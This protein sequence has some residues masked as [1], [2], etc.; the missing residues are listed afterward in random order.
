MNPLLNK[1]LESDANRIALSA[2]NESV[3]YGELLRRVKQVADTLQQR[4]IRVLALYADNSPNWVVVDLA[5]QMAQIVLLP[6]PLFFSTQQLHHA[7]KSCGNADALL[8]DRL[9]ESALFFQQKNSQ[10][11]A[12]LGYFLLENAQQGVAQLPP[13][14]Q[15]I[16]FTSGSTGTPKGVCLSVEQQLNVAQSLV[17]SIPL[18]RVRH[19]CVLPL[20]TLLENIAG[21]YAPLLR[22][23]EVVIPSLESIGISGSSGLD[24]MKFLQS[25]GEVAPT[26]LI[27]VPE[28]L[29]VL[30]AACEYGWQPPASLKFI[31]VGGARVSASLLHK[32][33]ASG[34][35]VYEGYGLSECASVVSLN[36]P[37]YDVIG[38]SGK[39][40][41]HV[42]V[43]VQNSE[44]V[45]SGNAYLGY[46]NEPDS[47]HQ[48]EIHTGDQGYVDAQG[49][50]HIEGRIKNVLISSFGRN[51][52]PEW[53]ESELLAQ[54]L[55]RQAVVLG[56]A[57]PFCCALLSP[58]NEETSDADI[59]QFVDAVNS[60]L[61]D[62][63]RIQKWHR[64]SSPLSTA[65][66]LMTENGRPK[67]E[68]IQHH[69][70]KT[71]EAFYQNIREE[72]RQ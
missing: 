59:Q 7:V 13:A 72:N 24:A 35:P 10:K 22:T 53:V 1:V 64:L 27:L 44:I 32:A 8:T 2:G 6:L 68:A 21:I 69:F 28:L 9:E 54:P 67:R 18:N 49:Y 63:A 30:V 48:N 37:E 58:R 42:K 5:C 38:S 34:L 60:K 20:S 45:V 4:N 71:I 61:P 62:Y 16:T 25:I 31:A 36:V 12:S 47:W 3:S 57:R 46:I 23:G 39:P 19:L 17:Q 40:L 65:D 55:L 66:G 51:I 15:K 50:I 14:T 11:L 52:N 70:H 33:R 56:D 26:T 29:M 41:P 43:S